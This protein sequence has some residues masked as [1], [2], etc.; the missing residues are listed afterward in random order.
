MSANTNQLSTII[1]NLVWIMQRKLLPIIVTRRALE[2]ENSEESTLQNSRQLWHH[3]AVSDG[4]E[5]EQ[6]LMTK[7][8]EALIAHFPNRATQRD[9]GD[10]G[11]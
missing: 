10:R 7:M 8:K 3:Y 5:A 9:D 2:S 4:A 1:S 11:T 6:L